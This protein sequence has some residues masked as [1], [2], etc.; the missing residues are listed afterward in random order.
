MSSQDVASFS[1]SVKLDSLIKNSYYLL[2]ESLSCVG[3]IF[4][5]SCKFDKTSNTYE[6][7]C[8]PVASYIFPRPISV[9]S[10]LEK[11]TLYSFEMET[12]LPKTS[13]SYGELCSAF[14]Y[15]SEPSFCFSDVSSFESGF[16]NAVGKFSQLDRFLFL[17]ESDGVRVFD[18]EFTDVSDR[19][20][21]YLSFV[22]TLSTD[23]LIFSAIFVGEY[24]SINDLYFNGRSLCLQSYQE[25]LK[26]MNDLKYNNYFKQYQIFTISSKSEFSAIE[27]LLTEI[28]STK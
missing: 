2:N 7:L 19:F 3:A 1:L 21:E 15:F 23:N 25:R 16:P 10:E 26:E 9:S 22:D 24:F 12:S 5:K 20:S 4:I 27:E 14:Q 17:K 6:Y 8:K 28:Q 13:L 18:S 11:N